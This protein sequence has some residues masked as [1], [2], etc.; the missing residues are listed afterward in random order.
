MHNMYVSQSRAHVM[1]LHTKLASTRK[2]DTPMVSYFAKMKAYADEMAAA[3]KQLEDDD[4]VS[5]ILAG[6]DEEYNGLVENV[7][8]RTDSISLSNLFAQLLTAEERNDNQSQAQMSA[9]AAACGGVPF[10]GRGGRD[11]GRG[12]HGDGCGAGRGHGQSS[13][14]P[15]CQICEKIGHSAGRCWKIF[16]REFKLEEKSVNSTMNNYGSSYGVD[17]K[18]YTNTGAT[19]HVT[20]EF[21]KLS[22]KEKYTR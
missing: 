4:I 8:S 17:T 9:N 3:G 18:W 14:R 5:Y 20:S 11:G 1:H 7:S 12:C 6:L 22:T 21:D 19:D 13:E 16:D 2:G 10:R 15:I